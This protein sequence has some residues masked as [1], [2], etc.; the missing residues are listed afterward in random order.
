[1]VPIVNVRSTF[2]TPITHF[3]SFEQFIDGSDGADGIIEVLHFPG[4]Y[5]DINHYQKNN[6]CEDILVEIS[7]GE[8]D[9]EIIHSISR[10]DY[11][12]TGNRCAKDELQ[13]RLDVHALVTSK[14][15]GTPDPESRRLWK[16]VP[17]FPIL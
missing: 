3:G 11:K 4:S 16:L 2:P 13:R 6:R 1:M 12:I 7:S 10:I 9:A 5:A 15:R 17:Q 14:F 8:E